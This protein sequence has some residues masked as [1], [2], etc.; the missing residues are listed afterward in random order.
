MVTS[1]GP[2]SQIKPLSL[3][4]RLQY[5][6]GLGQMILLSLWSIKPLNTKGTS[7]LLIWVLTTTTFNMSY[8][9]ML[10]T[11]WLLHQILVGNGSQSLVANALLTQTQLKS[12]PGRILLLHK[13]DN[14]IVAMLY[15][16][17]SLQKVLQPPLLSLPKALGPK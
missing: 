8:Q 6:Y 3:I 12:D 15:M 5:Y 7:I 9:T 4:K 16:Q 1:S 14:I 13:P 2:K 17:A 10:W 11:R